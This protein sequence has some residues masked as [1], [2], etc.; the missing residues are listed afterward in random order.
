M[1]RVLIG[2]PVRQKPHIFREYLDSLDRLIIPDGVEVDREFIL[3]GC[4]E[5]E[6]M[7]RP[8]DRRS[9]RAAADTYEVDGSTHVWRQSNFS[10]VAAMKNELLEHTRAGGYDYFMLVDSDLV[11]Q[12]ETLA[13]L[14][15]RDKH[16]IAEIFWTAWQEDGSS[17]GPN[18]W[19][20]DACTYGA[21]QGVDRY[22]EPGVHLTGGTGACILIDK[23]VLGNPL[24]CYSPLYNVSWT[25]WEDRAFCIRA[26]AHG[27]GIHI[28]TTCPAT[29]L[30]R[31]AD[32]QAYK[33]AQHNAP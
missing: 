16:I 6:P 11:L 9:H 23:Q 30:Y 28:D 29:H 24:I 18:C 3:H 33:E 20:Y 12:P 31:E 8:E 27:H 7:L 1:T 13:R 19:D 15:S 17:Y 2:A 32:Y 10:A 25:V 22:K 4:P 26:A 21:P 5:M 14:L